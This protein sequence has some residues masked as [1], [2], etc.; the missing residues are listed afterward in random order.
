MVRTASSA[1]A[2]PM[3]SAFATM[4]APHQGPAYSQIGPR[5]SPSP[6]EDAEAKRNVSL[7][8]VG[9]VVANRQPRAGSRAHHHLGRAAAV[10]H[11]GLS[12]TEVAHEPA[13]LVRLE[14]V[15]L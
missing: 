14:P 2:L 1:S 3:A 10:E 11:V 15:D 12:G 4:L 7:G 5:I 6:A 13:E 8:A 9:R